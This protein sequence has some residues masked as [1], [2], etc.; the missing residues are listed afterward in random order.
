MI[1]VDELTGRFSRLGGSAGT[2]E[3]S[4]EVID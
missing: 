4:I 3:S 1:E 2:E